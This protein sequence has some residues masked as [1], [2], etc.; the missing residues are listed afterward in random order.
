MASVQPLN[1][2]E[3]AQYVDREPQGG[4]QANL[5]KVYTNIE[6]FPAK[7]LTAANDEREGDVLIWRGRTWLCIGCDAFQSGVI[8]HF[9]AVFQEID[10]DVG[11]AAEDEGSAEE[12]SP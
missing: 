4:R 3:K 1:K 10:E 2:D 7:Q 12:I 9:R 6:L 8:S 5:V 11:E